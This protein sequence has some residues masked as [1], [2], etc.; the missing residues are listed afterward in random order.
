MKN[1]KNLLWIKMGALAVLLALLATGCLADAPDD[2]DRSM[3][4]TPSSV[5]EVNRPLKGSGSF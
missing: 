5:D 3:T 1:K 2:I 4:P